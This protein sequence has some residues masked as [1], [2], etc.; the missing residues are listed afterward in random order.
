MV[1]SKSGDGRADA[2]ADAKDESV[3]ERLSGHDILPDG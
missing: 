1:T 3:G 2:A